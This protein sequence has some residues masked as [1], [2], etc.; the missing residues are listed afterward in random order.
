MIPA[1]KRTKAANDLLKIQDI[2]PV[3]KPANEFTNYSLQELMQDWDSR[4][5]TIFPTFWVV[6]WTKDDELMFSYEGDGDG[7][8]IRQILV[9]KDM[10]VQVR[11]LRN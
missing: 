2:A 10:T 3:R 8:T 1:S 4:E 7:A 6:E 9:K 5:T 11:T